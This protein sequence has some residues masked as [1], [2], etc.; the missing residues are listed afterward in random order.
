MAGTG[1]GAGGGRCASGSGAA[2]TSRGEAG[3]GY[4]GRW[5]LCAAGS[6][7]ATARVWARAGGWGCNGCSERAWAGAGATKSSRQGPAMAHGSRGR[8]QRHAGRA[9][10]AVRGR[11]GR[12]ASARGRRVPA[13][14]DCGA[15]AHM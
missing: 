13:T 15:E 5:G 4:M 12:R 2:W 3:R 11:S 7:S 14:A 1:R 6:R 10:S 9:A 8:G